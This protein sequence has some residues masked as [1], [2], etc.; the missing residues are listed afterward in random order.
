MRL[1]IV[2]PLMFFNACPRKCGGAVMVSDDRASCISC[3]WVTY[4]EPEQREGVYAE[5]GVLM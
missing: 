5:Q 1:V 4:G 3:G 2:R